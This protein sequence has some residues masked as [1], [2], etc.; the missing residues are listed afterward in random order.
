M[1]Q[2]GKNIDH[3]PPGGFLPVCDGVLGA[4]LSGHIFVNRVMG[5]CA[6]YIQQVVSIRSYGA[7]DASLGSRFQKRDS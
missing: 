6:G 3:T 1:M 5:S 4:K 7:V 2:G